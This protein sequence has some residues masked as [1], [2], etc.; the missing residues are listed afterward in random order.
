MNKAAIRNAL[1]KLRKVRFSRA[2]PTNELMAPQ[3]MLDF[4]AMATGMKPVFLLG[5]GF[6]DPDWIAGVVQIAKEMGLRITVGPPW[7]AAESDVPSWFHDLTHPED[8][9][10]ADVVYICRAKGTAEAVEN[11][12]V[13]K[14]ISIEEEAQLLAYPEC[15]VRDHYRR[16]ELRDQAFFMMVERTAN[17]DREEMR[18][19]SEMTSD[20]LRKLTEKK[21]CSKSRMGAGLPPSQVSICATTAA[22]GLT[23]LQSGSQPV[24]RGSQRQSTPA[25]PMRLL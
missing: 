11:S 23:A 9:L 2:D 12:C 18:G 16:V 8:R 21:R 17:G 4:L 19:L 1:K 10:V 5:R 20:Y 22:T 25:L 3:E 13:K 24:S 7:Q 15:C 6:S 14:S